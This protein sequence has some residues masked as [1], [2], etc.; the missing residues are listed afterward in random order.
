MKV[1]GR[2]LLSRPRHLSLAVS[3]AVVQWLVRASDDRVL[4]ASNPSIAAS[5]LAAL[6]LHG[7]GKFVYPSLPVSFGLD[8]ISCWS[9]LYGVNDGGRKI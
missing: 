5:K 8:I 2:K 3:G 1:F 6:P 9:L 7:P 4:T